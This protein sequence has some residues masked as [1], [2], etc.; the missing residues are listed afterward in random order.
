VLAGGWRHLGKT[1]P[2]STND[3]V[4]LDSTDH[5][6]LARYFTG[7]CTPAE[8]AEVEEWLAARPGRAAELAG[9]RQVADALSAAPSRETDWQTVWHR[10]TADI[11][12]RADRSRQIDSPA[13]ARRKAPLAGN[14]P[15]PSFAHTKREGRHF[16]KYW[17]RRLE[18][19]GRASSLVWG[20]VRASL[21]CAL[22]AGIT[23]VL[24]RQPATH[25][26]DYIT[27]RGE[28][29]NVTLTDGTVIALAPASRVRVPDNYGRA[30]RQVDLEGE[31]FFRVVHDTA[32]P[33]RVVTRTVDAIDV[34]TAFDL[35]AYDED[36]IAE[37]AVTEGQVAARAT[38]SDSITRLGAGDLLSVASS[39][40][41][42][43][44]HRS[45]I[46]TTIGWTRGQLVFR[47]TPVH[48]AVPV[49]ERWYALTIRVEDPV[50]DATPLTATLTAGNADE[51]LNAVVAALGATW[52]R[53]NGTIL[54]RSR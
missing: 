42:A 31:A 35:R 21:L 48:D 22:A 5:P 15:H 1:Q 26:R 36:S 7:T 9:L 24:T 13:S 43:R 41:I 49:L 17:P 25:A 18:E 39:G 34:G 52:V 53:Q 46:G 6:L 14:F 8:R 12:A 4:P 27:R 16:E 33:F 10:L 29:L 38:N 23:F 30:T 2:T 45:D 50:L 47:N 28:R 3:P 54:L 40:R 11:A 20:A 32:H 37:V 19:G 44:F 51:M